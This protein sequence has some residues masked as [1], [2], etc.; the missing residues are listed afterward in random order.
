MIRALLDYLGA[1]VSGEGAWWILGLNAILLIPLLVARLFPP[2]VTK[3]PEA[4][5]AAKAELASMG[6]WSRAESARSAPCAGSI[7]HIA[8]PLGCFHL[9]Q[10][11][12][13]LAL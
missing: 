2:G 9:T 5:P 13:N 1:Q 8:A 12:P 4:P 3:T 11:R 10:N 7:R 6:A